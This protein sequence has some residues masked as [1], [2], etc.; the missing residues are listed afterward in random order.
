MEFLKLSELNSLLAKTIKE[1]FLSYYWIVAEIS[2]LR[3]NQTSGHCYL[4]L[5]EK[6]EKTGALF[7]KARA[8]IWNSTF[9]VIKPYFKSATGQELVSGIKVLVKVGLELHILYGYSLTIYDIDPSYTLGD[10]ERKRKE[11]IDQLE[12]E[13]VLNL[14]KELELAIL[15]QRIAI[16]SSSTAAG[17]EDFMAHLQENKEGLVFYTHLFPALMQGQQTEPSIIEALDKIYLHKDDF[18]LVVIIRG[19][20]ASTDLS[21]FDSYLLA[22]NCAQFPLPIITG[23]GHQR[24]ETVLD[25]VSYKRAKTPTAAADFLIGILLERLDDQTK[26]QNSII[27]RIEALLTGHNSDLNNKSF[28]IQGGFSE[29]LNKHSN[30]INTMAHQLIRASE[31][32]LH[33]NKSKLEGVEKYIQMS[34]PEYILS[35]GYSITRI[36]GK[37]I[38]DVGELKK[39]DKI[40]TTF[41]KG[42][43]SSR[44]E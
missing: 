27:G 6:N 43:V 13:G 42:R 16:I 3:V 24:D 40:E 15:P 32:L 33:N 12:E 7:A 17:F 36:K 30:N 29:L 31:H 37:A 18:D 41:K 38:F 26:L 21:A 9:Q 5:I 22:A 20:G 14:N 1:N 4:E 19:G 2:D 28:K 39:G 10:Q 44:V 35:K 11:I 34:S 25:I 23:I 8:N